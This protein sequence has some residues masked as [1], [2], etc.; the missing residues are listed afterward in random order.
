M[1][2]VYCPSEDL[3]EEAISLAKSASLQIVIGDNQFTQ[4]LDFDRSKVQVLSGHT[5]NMLHYLPRSTMFMCHSVMCYSTTILDF[6]E[7]ECIY[8]FIDATS[9]HFGEQVVN[10]EAYFCEQ[11]YA[12]FLTRLPYPGVW[13]FVVRLHRQNIAHGEV[14]VHETGRYRYSGTRG[15]AI[16][17]YF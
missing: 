13:S 7:S 14:E 16:Q 5:N 3:L 2:L 9:P 17:K 6:S 10:S 1:R 11:G 15:G 8:E 4:D 12:R